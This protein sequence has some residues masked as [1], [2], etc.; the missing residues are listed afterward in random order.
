MGVA[1]GRRCRGRA[2]AVVLKLLHR[3]TLG[4]KEGGA[5]RLVKVVLVWHVPG[6]DNPT[7]GS[8]FGA[9]ALTRL[10]EI[11]ASNEFL[12]DSHLVEERIELLVLN[13]GSAKV[14]ETGLVRVVALDDTRDILEEVNADVFEQGG[15]VDSS[16][17][18]NSG[19][20]ASIGAHDVL[21]SGGALVI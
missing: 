19:D 17:W 13:D 15:D 14:K 2:V 12:S 9:L 21:V 10:D 1:R 20:G 7:T 4:R 18:C 5:R 6:L 11:D 8:V 3:G 16:G